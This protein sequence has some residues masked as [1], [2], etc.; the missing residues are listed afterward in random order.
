MVRN[1]TQ[2]RA[3][4]APAVALVVFLR[5]VNVGG[6]RRFSPSRVAEQ[7]RYLDAVSI[8]AAGTF[9]IRRKVS[10]EQLRREFARRVPFEAHLAICEGQDILR[11]M[12]HDFFA[13]HAAR[14][15]LVRFVSVLSAR[16]RSTPRTPMSLPSSGE[17][18]VKIF[19]REDRFIVG[20]YRR[21]MKVISYLSE[22]DR[23]FGVPATTRSW[24][25]LE[26]IAKLLEK[27]S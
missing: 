8:G 5:G 23:V 13:G 9:V 4:I 11:L 25:T 14:P 6:H 7:L 16:P 20:L 3:T 18:L 26:A 19:A 2:K 17:W 21:R 15:D 22:L 24:S 12:S 1:D 10:R 27:P